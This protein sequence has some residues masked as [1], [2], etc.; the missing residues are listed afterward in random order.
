M[1]IFIASGI[2]HPDSGGP[3]TY[4][5]RLLPELQQRGHEVRALAYGDTPASGYPYPLTRIPFQF[6]PIRLAKYALA[7]R[8]GAAWADLVYL[9]SLGLPR[10][11]AGAKPKVMKVVGDYAWERAVNRGWLPATED[12]DAFQTTT[13]NPRIEAFKAAR[14]RE[15]QRVDRVIVPSDY[16]RRM[17]IGWGADPARVQVIYNALD[18]QTYDQPMTKAQARQQLGW[19]PDG[20]YLFTA[21]R[22]TAWKG[23]DYLIDALAHVP[24]VRLIVAGDGPHKIALEARAKAASVDV[25]FVGKV[26]HDRMAAYMRAAD[27]L[28]LY[29]G[30]EGLSHTILEA[31]YAGTP[32]IASDRGGNPEIVQSGVNGLLVKHPDLPALIEALQTA[33]DADTPEKLAAGTAHGLDRFTWSTLVNQTV[34]ALVSTALSGRSN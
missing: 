29:S 34:E 25:Q 18:S 27:Y 22:L 3:A 8:R 15:V 12:I 20:R 30:Y 26:P 24:N 6:L 7:Y 33:F 11:G 17:V 14:A 1:R 32:V 21:A 31:L 28:A 2:F 23:V 10:S 5:Y 16:L 19:Q 4:L 13:Y 9:N